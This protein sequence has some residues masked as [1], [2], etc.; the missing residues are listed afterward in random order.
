MPADGSSSGIRRDRLR[1]RPIDRWRVWLESVFQ[2][3]PGFCSITDSSPTKAFTASR[4]V[5]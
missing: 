2:L 4:G 5:R 1:D 3:V